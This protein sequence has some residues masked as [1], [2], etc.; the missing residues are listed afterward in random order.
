MRQLRTAVIGLGRVGWQFHVP[1]IINHEGFALVAVVD[2]LDERLAEAQATF[3]P[4]LKEPLRTYRDHLTMLEEAKPDLVVICSPTRFH[5]EQALAAFAHGYDVFCDKPMAPTLEEAD[6][7]IAAARDAGRKLMVYQPHRA[8]VE[9]VALQDILR[10]GILGPVYMMKRARSAFTRRNDWQALRKYGGGMLNNYG[11]HFVDQLLYLAGSR[12]ARIFCALRTIASLGDADDVVKAVIETENGIILDLDINMAAA[13]P[14]TPWVIL[15]RCGSA[16][17]DESAHT[18]RVRYFCP[19]D[20]ADISLDESLAAPGR[21]YASGETIPWRE[22]SFPLADYAPVD[23]YTKVYDYYALD[24][25]PFVP[26]AES[27][28]VMRVLDMCRRDAERHG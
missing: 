25:T 28:E 9:V 15:G 27:R 13:V 23:F 18:W 7:M 20:L 4:A 10:R 16:T 14:L 2:P 26:I 24:A 19:T 11:A 21:K 17:L 22:E 3:G 8:M 6:T 12:A 5:L 1:Q